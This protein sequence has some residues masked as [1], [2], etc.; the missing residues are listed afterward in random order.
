M[1]L[2]RGHLL[3]SFSCMAPT[4]LILVFSSSGKCGQDW[5]FS[6]GLHIS[7]IISSSDKYLDLRLLPGTERRPSIARHSMFITMRL[8]KAC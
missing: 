7:K 2:L 3:H 6:F 4:T 5:L 8:L 1:L